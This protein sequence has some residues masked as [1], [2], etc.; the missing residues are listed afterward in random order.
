MPIDGFNV[1]NT[2]VISLSTVAFDGCPDI[3]PCLLRIGIAAKAYFLLSQSPTEA[4]YSAYGLRMTKGD[5]PVT[6]AQF[7]ASLLKSGRSLSP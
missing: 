4:F 1:P 6:Y 2:L 7:R 5:T 3:L